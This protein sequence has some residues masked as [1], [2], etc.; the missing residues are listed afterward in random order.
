MT[1]PTAATRLVQAASRAAGLGQRT[2][3]QLLASFV[4]SNDPSAFEALV[5]RHGPLVLSACRQVLRDDAAADD[6]FQA[7]FVLLH[8]KAKSIRNRPS[9]AGWLFR[10]AR[11]CATSVRRSAQRRELREVRAA[12]PEQS[13]DGSWADAVE[14]LHT[15][16]DRL[17]DTYRLPLILC[18]LEGLSRDEAAHRLGST[19]NEVRGRLERG[20]SRLRDRLS[21]R[22]ITLSA[23]LLAFVAANRALPASLV[24]S[25]V[26]AARSVSPS[27][28]APGL[29]WAS[30]LGLAVA[31]T[32]VLGVALQYRDAQAQPTPEKPAP[33]AKADAA[34]PPTVSGRVLDPDG[35]PVANAKVFVRPA[36]GKEPPERAVVTDT[37]GLF[38]LPVPGTPRDTAITVAATADGFAAGWE[39]W[40]GA[41]RGDLTL[42]LAKDDRP[43]E[44]RVFDLQGQ[45]IS[46]VKVHF[47][48]TT[49]IPDGGPKAYLQW[50]NRQRGMPIHNTISGA[51]PGATAE[52]VTDAA[53]RFRLT[54]IGRDRVAQLLLT[55]P[56]IAHEHVYVLTVAELDP[57]PAG[58]S[59]RAFPARFDVVALPARPIHGVVRD[60]DTGQPVAGVR[61]NGFG[62]ATDATTDQNGRYELPGYRKGPKYNVYAW[63][64]DGS[65][66]FP[67][68]AEA[69]DRA[70]LDPL[71]INL[72]VRAGIP[73][74]GRIRD[75][76][77]GKPVAGLVR[78]YPL[79]G[80]PNVTSVS[81]GEK[82]GEFFTLNVKTRADGS[83]TCAVLPGRGFLAVTADPSR[84]PSARVDPKGFV[85]DGAKPPHDP[86]QLWVSVGG[87]AI[88]SVSQES[89]QA[90]V[91]LNVDPKKPP[92]EQ[93][94]ELAPAEPVRGRLLDPDGKPLL[95]VRVRG[96]NR[97]EDDWSAPLRDAEFTAAPP[98]PDRPRRLTF[99]QDDRKL[100]RAAEVKVGS[101]RPVEIK[102]EPWSSLTGRLVDVE[103]K[104]VTPA[105]VFAPGRRG[106]QGKVIDMVRMSS[107]FTDAD[108][109][110]T[111]NGLFSGVSYDLNFRE[112][113]PGGRGGVLKK[114]VELKPGE[115]RQLGDLK[116]P[117]P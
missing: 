45:P 115:H 32:V 14:V 109:R 106:P 38:T 58:R 114:D 77:N 2:D 24:T 52:A 72:T 75:V 37:A 26:L 67:G 61:V 51:P 47:T 76:A 92:G 89:F 96:L 65:T 95:G 73:V 69:N 94:I 6:V 112:I 63:P 117:P 86:D 41:A 53:G 108:G 46:G 36:G 42:A 81:V 49:A 40:G 56:G 99:R 50:I 60:A 55:G 22:G 98:H 27:R 7:T 12:K 18:Y 71:E 103:G 97:S 35:K 54:G 78:Y 23:G 59:R 64:A 29:T 110:F 68:L 93:V 88:S 34:K 105:S 1:R 15:E 113:K 83:F 39:S 3:S 101:E 11:R 82:P 84:Y 116:V 31:A 17:P 91:F 25:T 100:V 62:G 66:Y 28:L 70:G 4:D 87:A 111:I 48:E 21:R 43:I 19:L 80:N 8:Q 102:L 20:R 5:R 79:A 104:P 33:A 107:V 74:A 13:F 30:G 85:E 10:V 90:I 16:L 9:L 57:K 44:G